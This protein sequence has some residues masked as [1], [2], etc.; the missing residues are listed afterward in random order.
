MIALKGTSFSPHPFWDLLFAC[1][2]TMAIL[3]GL[4]WY[5]IVILIFISLIMSDVEHF[6]MHLL[7]ICMSSLEKFLFRSSAQFLI[8]LF[9]WLSCMSCLYILE[10]NPLS[11]A[12]IFSHS[13]CCLLVLFIASFAVQILKRG[14]EELRAN[15]VPGIASWPAYRFLGRQGR[16]SGISV[17]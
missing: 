15:P 16:W 2:L 12:I 13:E 6:L 4:R 17:S 3:T 10:I 11:F 8:G 14:W 9:S 7:A 1:F 5:L